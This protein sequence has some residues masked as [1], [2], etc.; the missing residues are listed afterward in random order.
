M[1]KVTALIV[2]D[3]DLECKDKKE[4][5]LEELNL[6]SL[7][8]NFKDLKQFDLIVYSGKKGRK[9]LKCREI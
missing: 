9:I 6:A 7:T 2:N 1:R 4:K 8:F 5:I 3:E